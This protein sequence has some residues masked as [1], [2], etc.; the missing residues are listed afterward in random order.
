MWVEGA[1]CGVCVVRVCVCVWCLSGRG[2]CRRN[3]ARRREEPPGCVRS[4]LRNRRIAFGVAS[5]AMQ[6]FA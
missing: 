2:K 1:V 5:I 6:P 3:L 4:P